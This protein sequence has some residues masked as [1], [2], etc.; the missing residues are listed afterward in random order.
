[1]LC[2]SE[3][4]FCFLLLQLFFTN[5]KDGHWAVVVAN[6]MHKQFN[7]FDSRGDDPDYVSILEKPCCNLVWTL[8]LFPFSFFIFS[9]YKFCSCGTNH[10]RFNCVIH[11]FATSNF[12]DSQLQD[13]GQRTKPMETWL[14]QVWSS[15]PEWVPATVNNVLFSDHFP[16]FHV[17]IH[18]FFMFC[19]QVSKFYMY[20]VTFFYFGRFDC[21]LFAILYMENLTGRGMRPF[22]AVFPFCYATILAK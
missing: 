6:L 8:H 16:F 7:I 9:I 11:L 21:G 12:V 15:Q 19:C 13:F 4:I 10:T 14:W 1:M 3:V 18:N 2:F 20:F 5:V 22:S 17:S